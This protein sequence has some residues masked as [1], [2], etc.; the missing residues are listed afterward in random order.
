MTVGASASSYLPDYAEGVCLRSLDAGAD[1]ATATELVTLRRDAIPPWW[2]A[3]GMVRLDMLVSSVN[4]DGNSYS[5]ELGTLD[6]EN[7]FRAFA[8]FNASGL[9]PKSIVVATRLL[10]P[11]G[12]KNLYLRTNVSGSNSPLIA[13]S[14]HATAVPR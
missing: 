11:Q 3:D 10:F 9:G 6:Q 8:T 12:A 14:L 4:L 7:V 2:Q 1:T 5:V 13:Y